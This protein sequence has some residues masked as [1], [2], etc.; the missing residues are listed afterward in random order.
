M[1]KVGQT[2]SITLNILFSAVTREVVPQPQKGL[3]CQWLYRVAR[4]GKADTG[5]GEA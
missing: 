2:G 3:S 5:L 1:C 4:L